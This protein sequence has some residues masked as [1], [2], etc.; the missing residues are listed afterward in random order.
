MNL[1]IIYRSRSKGKQGLMPERLRLYT[2]NY[3]NY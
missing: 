1:E 2:I 3:K